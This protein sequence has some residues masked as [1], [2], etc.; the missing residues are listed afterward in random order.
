MDCEEK[1]KKLSGYSGCAI[2]LCKKNDI[3][4]VRKYSSDIHYN[5]RLIKQAQKQKDFSGIGCIKAP[6]VLNDG[7]ENG[8]Y[9]FDMEYLRGRTLAECFD[10]IPFYKIADIID[11]LAF[12]QRK[13]ILASGEDIE[14]YYKKIEQLEQKL[15]DSFKL[16]EC[17][18]LLKSID[19]EEFYISKCHG[20]LTLENIIITENKGVYLIDFLDSFVDSWQIDVAKLLQDFYVGWSFRQKKQTKNI[21][22]RQK[23]MTER[24]D[25]KLLQLYK[26][27][28]AYRNVYLLLL[29]NLIR[30]LPYARDQRTCNYLM[31]AISKVSNKIKE[32]I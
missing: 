5:Q 27:T 26:G 6:R 23:V 25:N 21:T 14:K 10:A 11:Q 3:F 18:C 8:L 12:N 30:I 9:Y 7:Y 20:D 32:I 22:I 28:N 17:F 31:N 19:Q 13:T 15:E 29:M 2:Y 16:Y 4:F 1:L 24:I